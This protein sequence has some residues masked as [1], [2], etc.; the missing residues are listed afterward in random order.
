MVLIVSPLLFKG[1]LIRKCNTKSIVIIRIKPLQ[2]SVLP[3]KDCLEYKITCG[4]KLLLLPSFNPRTKDTHLS[5][6]GLGHVQ[7]IDNMVAKCI[8]LAILK[9][10]VTPQLSV[11]AKLCLSTHGRLVHGGAIYQ[12]L[13][14]TVDSTSVISLPGLDSLDYLPVPLSTTITKIFW[15]HNT[16][17]LS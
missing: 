9:I 13:I 11:R 17:K 6:I 3:Q 10:N 16:H 15:R 4:N 2:A 8:T 12:W 5:I 1:R 14:R 7:I